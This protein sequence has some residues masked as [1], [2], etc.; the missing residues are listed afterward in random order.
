MARKSRMSMLKR[1]RELKKA[2]KAARKRAKRH[3]LPEAFSPE[4]LPTVRLG[5]LVG[6]DA[7]DDD[8]SDA[9]APEAEPAE[10]GQDAD[11]AR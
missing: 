10:V 8:G 5:D 2:E 1:Q 4:P 6:Q 9:D 3:G 7:S 11:E